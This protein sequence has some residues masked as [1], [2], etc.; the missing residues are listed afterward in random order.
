MAA[1]TRPVA[2]LHVT[3]ADAFAAMGA[4]DQRVTVAAATCVNQR[5]GSGLAVG[6][7]AVTELHQGDEARIEIDPHLGE[8][9]LL[10][11]RGAGR[12]LTEDCELRQ[13]LQAIRERS[14]RD[15]ER[16][17]ERFERLR[18][19]KRFADDQERPCVGN[20]VERARNRTVP[21]ASRNARPAPDRSRNRSGGGLYSLNLGSWRA[22]R[23]ISLRGPQVAGRFERC[24]RLTQHHG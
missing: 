17:T 24:A 18:P 20:D 15:A 14:P 3:R 4:G 5:Q 1:G 9:I 12:D 2:V 6:K 16:R 10:A 7:P 19:E 11:L 23:W 22:S 13:L 21:F 8:A